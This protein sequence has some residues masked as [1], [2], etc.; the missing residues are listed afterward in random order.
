MRIK[1]FTYSSVYV[2]LLLLGLL[3]ISSS[4]NTLLGQ[5]KQREKKQN[6]VEKK[7]IRLEKRFSKERFITIGIGGLYNQTQ[8]ERMELSTFDGIGG[9]GR[10]AYESLGE[11]YFWSV[12]LSGLGGI[13]EPDHAES[14]TTSARGDAIISVL[15]NIPPKEENKG[16]FSVGLSASSLFQYRFNRR[17]ANSAT[18]RDWI[19]SL[20]LAGTWRKD[21]VLWNQHMLFQYA[22][23]LPL[24]SYI[25]RFPEFAT[26]LD[27]YDNT[28]TSW[29]TFTRFVSELSVEKRLGRKTENKM[30]LAYQ[31]DFYSLDESI[32]HQ[33]RVANHTLIFSLLIKM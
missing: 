10:L 18:N 9:A 5:N 30:R 29:N 22:L 23:R 2:A 12:E 11:K 26:S 6:R 7:Q 33:L 14:Q 4:L 8:D 1:T 25:K 13:L 21:L 27:G 24:V 31:W 16:M 28:F 15:R 20:E 17:L 19:S 3:L 32:V